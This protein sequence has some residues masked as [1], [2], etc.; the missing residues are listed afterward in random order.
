MDL[1]SIDVYLLSRVGWN[2]FKP[3]G[4]VKRFIENGIS[5]MWVGLL[6]VVQLSILPVAWVRLRYVELTVDIFGWVL[7]LVHKISAANLQGGTTENATNNG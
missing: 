6:C 3:H 1:T 7:G 5:S 4:I 2:T